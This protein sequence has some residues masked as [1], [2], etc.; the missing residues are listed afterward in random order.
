MVQKY[1]P[2]PARNTVLF[3]MRYAAPRRGPKSWLS[4][5][6]RLPGSPAWSAVFH[7][8]PR[9]A[10]ELSTDGGIPGRLSIVV[11]PGVTTWNAFA[12]FRISTLTSRLYLSWYGVHF[13][14]RSPSS[15]V[16]RG[17]TFQLSW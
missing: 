15:T 10:H 1:F 3:V 7:V 17:V 5:G 9:A 11:L 13:S 14:H 6:I 12:K 8:R 4:A 2:Y 16:R